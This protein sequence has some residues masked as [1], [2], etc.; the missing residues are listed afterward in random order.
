[1]PPYEEHD[2]DELIDALDASHRDIAHLQRELLRLV[3]EADRRGIWRRSGARD[4]SHWLAIRHGISQWKA[5]RWVGAAHAL[6]HLT[7][8]GHALDAGELGIDKVVE[9]ARFAEFETEAGLIA[10]AR[11]VSCAAVRRKADVEVRRTLDDV[12]EAERA[13]FLNWWHVDDGNRLGLEGEL[14]AAQ[15]AIVVNALQRV[16]DSMPWMPGEQDPSYA[17]ARR[18]DALVALCSQR[19]AEDADPDR[20]TVV[21][22]ARLGDVASRGAGEIEGGGRL[23]P[24]TVRRLLCDARVQAV[25]EN[26]DGEPIRLGRLSREPSPAMMRQLRYR[27]RECRFPGCGSRRFTQAHHVVW[28]R[29]GGTT[30]LDNLVLV[31]FFHHRLV[32]EHGWRIELGRDGVVRWFQPEGR[33][34]HPSVL[35]R[36][37]PLAS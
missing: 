7:D 33:P 15:G 3:A 4:L 18:A 31:C 36:A 11:R 34:R 13:R 28:W 2:D 19:I 22:H 37:G 29:D 30:D 16:T 20:A 17:E 9:L 27:D 23:H 24:E 26:E 25:V 12:R 35:A 32:H 14:P 5:R 6:E 10:W 21:V 1:M 8:L